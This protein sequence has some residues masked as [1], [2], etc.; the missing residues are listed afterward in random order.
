MHERTPVPERFHAFISYTTREE[1]VRELKPIVDEF[2]NRHLGA[3][4]RARVRSTLLLRR[5]VSKKGAPWIRRSARRAAEGHLGQR[6]V[7]G[8]RFALLY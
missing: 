5:L 3:E 8:I 2:L 7:A 4:Y 1:E 6:N